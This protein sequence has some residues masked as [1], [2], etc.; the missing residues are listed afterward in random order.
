MIDRY[1]TVSGRNARVICRD[2]GGFGGKHPILALIADNAGNEIGIP[3]GEDLKCKTSMHFPGENLDLIEIEEDEG[4]EDDTLN[5]YGV[6]AYI[7]GGDTRYPTL[8]L[9]G[10]FGSKGFNVDRSN[11][12]LKQVCVCHAYSADECCCGGWDNVTRT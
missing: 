2:R 4:S 10:A 5:E 12:N 9:Q 7:T 8:V 6:T 1:K 3:Y 11:G